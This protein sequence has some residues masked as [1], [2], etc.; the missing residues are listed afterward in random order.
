MGARPIA[1]MN[2]LSFGAPDH[3]KTKQL[4]NGRAQLGLVLERRQ[5]HVCCLR[6]V[7]RCY[8]QIFL[9]LLGRIFHLMV[10]NHFLLDH[11]LCIPTL[12][13]HEQPNLTRVE[14]VL[15]WTIIRSVIASLGP[16]GNEASLVLP[17]SI[18]VSKY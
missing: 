15:H 1:A 11:K 3:P 14:D 6:Q 9:G 2:S 13:Y 16:S 18:S 17:M 4:V 5:D 7:L 12:H 8:L 10:H